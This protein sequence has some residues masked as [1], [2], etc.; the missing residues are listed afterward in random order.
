[1]PNK[2]SSSLKRE[3]S[4]YYIFVSIAA[5]AF[6]IFAV[7]NEQTVGLR[8]TTIELASTASALFVLTIIKQRQ[9]RFPKFISL[10]F[11]FF[12][13]WQFLSGSYSKDLGETVWEILRS[14]S[15]FMLFITTYNLCRNNVSVQKYMLA[16][17]SFL[18]T[19][20]LIKDFAAFI[21][22]GELSSGVYFGGTFYWHNQMAGFLIF[23][24]PILLAF[25]LKLNNPIPKF[26]T[27]AVIIFTSIMMV[28]TY[29]RGG[30]I[31]LGVSLI[32][33]TALSF[34][35]VKKHLK[36][37]VATIG[38]I[39]FLT[40]IIMKSNVLS[41]QITSIPS[42]TVNQTRSV[43]GKLRTTVWTNAVKMV[44]DNPVF[45]VGPGAFGA[46][47][48]AYQ[49]DPWLYAK[50]AHNH[51]LETAAE[52]GIPG[53]LLYGSI[54][55]SAT[56]LFLK[57][58]TKVI[59]NDGLLTVAVTSALVG[60]TAHAFIDFDWSRIALYSLFWIMLAIF[61]SRMNKNETV[62]PLSGARVLV[63]FLP[64]IVLVISSV[65]LIAQRDAF[66]AQNDLA[67]Q[68]NLSV[69]RAKLENAIKINPIDP[70]YYLLLG[71][72]EDAQDATASAI[73]SYNKSLN[74]APLDANPYY[75]QGQIYYRNNDFIQAENFFRKA[76][77]IN[78]YTHPQ[79]YLSL[80]DAQLKQ[81]KISEA[82]ITLETAIG[83]AFPLND[84]YVGFEYLYDYTG[85][86]KDLAYTYL[87]LASLDIRDKQYD[88]AKALLDTVQKRLD[89]D[90]VLW[91]VVRSQ[92]PQ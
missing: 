42:E 12:L 24:I 91:P 13:T 62:V 87:R 72:I 11:L 10:I 83:K 85:L 82:K 70:Q 49:T 55:I 1:M 31:S 90:N 53:I 33:F 89:P 77:D 26:V 3:N 80:S 27:M 14:L 21:R 38:I 51:F 18:A 84:S 76:V 40:P 47:Y 32:L 60:S 78:P 56:L 19:A 4:L 81:Q 7:I 92:I 34:D 22:S 8:N 44:K 66:S 74:L 36:L 86:K 58:R 88:Q 5:I 68:R 30:W 45:G 59:K 17:F 61:F 35:A 37:L 15:Y 43:S 25:F 28:V 6:V 46:V 39:V 50:N 65:L 71:N 57:N 67:D 54:F 73:A 29:S 9:V 2:V 48:Y 16:S 63:Y 79:L 69:A 20:V 75:L 64:I 23:V 52:T 41:Q